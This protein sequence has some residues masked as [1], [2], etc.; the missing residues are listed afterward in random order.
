MNRDP[1]DAKP[2]VVV[3]WIDSRQDNGWTLMEDVGEPKPVYIDSYGRLIREDATCI[4]LSGHCGYADSEGDVPDQ[5]CGSMVIPK[6]SII[7]VFRLKY[8]DDFPLNAEPDEVNRIEVG[9]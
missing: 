3:R 1:L 8:G 9:P 7:S 4:T 6:V 2:L 5:V